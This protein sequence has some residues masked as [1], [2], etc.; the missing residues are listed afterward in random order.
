[1]KKI[2]ITGSTKGIGREVVTLCLRAGMTVV[3]VARNHDKMVNLPGRYI[4]FSLDLA[5]VNELESQFKQIQTEHTDIDAIICCAGFGNFKEIEQFSFLDMQRM[6][7]VN[8]LSQA[9]LIKTFLPRLKKRENSKV[10]FLG[11]EAALVGQ[12]KGSMYCA[13][14]FA[15]R[16]FAQSIRQECRGRDVAVTLVNPGFVRT[17]FFDEL[18]FKPGDDKQHAI[19]A[20]Q[21]ANMIMMTLN[22]HNNCVLEEINCQPMQ[23][24]IAKV[25]SKC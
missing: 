17:S 6:V 4:S 16:G 25:K 19:E 7:N 12:K 3:G 22:M 13:S 8:F 18:E 9:L 1:M 21:V 10:I 11:S 14:K 20:E 24:V 5:N 2:L 23:K 15:L